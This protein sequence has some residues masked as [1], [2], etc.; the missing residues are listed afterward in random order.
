MATGRTRR[1]G[2]LGRLVSCPGLLT[3][4]DL[5]LYLWHFA[6]SGSRV[7]EVGLGR[8]GRNRRFPGLSPT[9]GFPLTG[10]GLVSLLGSV[11]AGKAGIRPPA[12]LGLGGC[13]VFY[14][15]PYFFL[16]DPPVSPSEV[17]DIVPRV[18][19]ITVDWWGDHLGH[20]L[21]Y[22]VLGARRLIIRVG[23]DGHCPLLCLIGMTLLQWDPG[24][25]LLFSSPLC[26]H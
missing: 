21:R 17:S 19:T 26:M 14:G 8:T 25:S 4:F 2:G 15:L 6:G 1:R 20:S 5:H 9:S 10:T 12:F 11:G 23:L 3:T 7:T 16:K 13:G 22:F 24:F 18:P